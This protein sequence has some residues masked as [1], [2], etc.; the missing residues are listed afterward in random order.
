MSE[1]WPCGS[2]V[3][4]LLVAIVAAGSMWAYVLIVWPESATRLSDLYPRWYGSRELLLHGRN[5][6]SS[7]VSREIQVWQRGRPS[8]RR[9]G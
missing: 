6:Y 8:A 7:D 9:R 5:P 2:N 3:G 1:R 4:W